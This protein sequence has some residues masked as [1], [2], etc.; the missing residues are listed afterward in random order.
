QY[1]G[2]LVTLSSWTDIWVNEGFAT[3][4]ETDFH[5]KS[6]FDRHMKFSSYHA[7]P[8][9]SYGMYASSIDI[10]N[11]F[12]VHSRIHYQKAAQFLRMIRKFVGETVFDRAIH[13]YLLDNS[14]GNGD[15]PKII[16]YLL[17]AYEGDREQLKKIL[18]EWI[19]QVVLL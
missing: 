18:L 5:P 1:F 17:D 7:L 9:H 11:S 6:T 10:E 8:I 4:L 19:Y 2:N 16:R 3:L 12:I 14:Y 13:K 15:A